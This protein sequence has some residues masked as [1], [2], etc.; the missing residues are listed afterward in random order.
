MQIDENTVLAA[1]FG[2]FDQWEGGLTEDKG[3]PGGI[4]NY[5]TDLR[6]LRDF[7]KKSQE[8][9]DFL[10]RIGVILPITP[11]SIRALSRDQSHAYYKLICWIRPR[12]FEFG[13]LCAIAFFDHAT[14]GG[15]SASTKI[16]QRVLGFTGAEIDG[17]PGPQTR[18]EVLRRSQR[19]LAVSMVDERRQWYISLAD[20]RPDLR[21]ALKGWLNRT[22]ALKSLITRL[23]TRW[24][25]A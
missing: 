14:N 4:T 7:S 9:R 21:W 8:N 16:L 18:G 15:I 3:D 1:A 25:Y 19:V 23:A 2:H 6:S 10:D 12:A 5:G 11:N 17:I 24:G 20:K 22:D 13:P